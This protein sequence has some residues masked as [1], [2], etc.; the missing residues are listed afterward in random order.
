M[1]ILMLD[2]ETA[3]NIA[4]TWGAWQQNIGMNQFKQT[5]YM[6]C[7]GAKWY[8]NKKNPVHFRSVEDGKQLMLDELWGLLDEA[9]AVVHYNGKRFD[10]PMINWEFLRNDMGPP[11]PYKQVDLLT[12][13]R[14][15]FKAQMNK[16]DFVCQ[17]LELGHKLKHDGM[18]LWF[19]CMA[20]D[21][22]A[23]K[24]MKKYNIKDVKLLEQLY[25]KL[26]PWITTHPN[27]NMWNASG[28]VVCPKCSS[29]RLQKRGTRKTQT[30]EY[31]QYQCQSCGH[32]P[33]SNRCEKPTR[34]LL[35]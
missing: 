13:M 24:K 29:T 6:L 4:A 35:V 12:T 9:D 33:S 5:S 15:K 26:L 16:L 25:E 28:S 8:G 30:R 32:W 31:Q 23:W 10:I 14:S 3:P 21:E 11:S 22:K 7:W 20:G 1:N 18:E 27:H 19:K 34:E 2:I 17:E